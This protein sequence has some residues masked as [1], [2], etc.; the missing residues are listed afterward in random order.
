MTFDQNW[1]TAS[2]IARSVASGEVSAGA[3]VE[4]ALARITERDPMY[5]AF[6][7]VTAQR[8][9][10]RLRRGQRRNRG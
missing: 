1:A 4:N 5:N 10:R 9:R 3:V 8:A 7:D 2:E 6:T